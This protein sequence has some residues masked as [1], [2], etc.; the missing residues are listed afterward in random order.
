MGVNEEFLDTGEEQGCF[1]RFSIGLAEGCAE[2]SCHLST[3]G[4]TEFRVS[5]ESIQHRA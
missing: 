2:L 4:A 3:D 1:F 5:I